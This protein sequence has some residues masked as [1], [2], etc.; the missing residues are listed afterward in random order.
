MFTPH[1]RTLPLE[2]LFI[3]LDLLISTDHLPTLARLIRIHPTFQPTIERAL[4]THRTHFPS[5]SSHLAYLATCAQ[6]TRLAAL[7]RRYHLA[8]PTPTSTSGFHHPS[9]SSSSA[10]HKDDIDKVVA[11]VSNMRNLKHFVVDM[12]MHNPFDPEDLFSALAHTQLESFEWSTWCRK[13]EVADLIRTQPG[14]R[15]IKTQFL[16]A[17][18]VPL[19]KECCR[20]LWYVC[21]DRALLEALVPGREVRVV[22][23]TPLVYEGDRPVTAALA[24]GIDRL[25][26]LAFDGKRMKTLPLHLL[27]G[28]GKRLEVLQVTCHLSSHKFFPDVLHHMKHLESIIIICATEKEDN[29]QR[30]KRSL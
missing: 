20:G 2:L 14:L 29:W 5:R 12:W 23:W 19:G 15:Y 1:T 6:N 3:I 9:T 8:S 4:Y 24:Q 18:E 7:V 25:R 27:S 17:P 26:A 11:A 30:D 10:W 22:V 13:E 21:G 28:L 16:R